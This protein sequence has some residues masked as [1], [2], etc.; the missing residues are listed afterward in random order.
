MRHSSRPG[1]GAGPWEAAAPLSTRSRTHHLTPPGQKAP[2]DLN[3]GCLPAASQCS[4]V[5]P[6]A[7]HA[8]C[9]RSGRKGLLEPHRYQ[10]LDQRHR[11]GLIDTEAQGPG[12]GRVTLELIVQLGKDRAAV[13]QV[14]Q[15]IL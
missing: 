10:L 9:G 1:H 14:A 13:R 6:P 15:V 3:S 11:K 12:R 4:T 2:G 8:E 5:T 7:H